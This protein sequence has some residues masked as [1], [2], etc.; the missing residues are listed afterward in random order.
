MSFRLLVDE[1]LPPE[2]VGM[3]IAAGYVES[4]CARDRGLLAKK[5][6]VFVH[7][8]LARFR[9]SAS[10]F[11]AVDISSMEISGKPVRRHSV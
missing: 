9:E 4:T 8:L 10:L 7:G 6:W 2:L 11:A 5:D 3:A 1:C